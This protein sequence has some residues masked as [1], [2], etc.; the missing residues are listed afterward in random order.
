MKCPNCKNKIES[1]QKFCNYCGAPIPPKSQKK[2]NK[3]VILPVGVAC[4]CGA[5]VLSTILLTNPQ[6]TSAGK[7]EKKI[8]AGNRYLQQADYEKAEVAFNEALSID[9]K[10]SDAALG[11]AK[12]CNEKKNPEGAIK[13]LELATDNLEEMKPDQVDKKEEKDWE[14]KSEEYKQTFEDTNRLF[15]EKGNTKQAEYVQQRQQKAQQTFQVIQTVK[16]EE[17]S[18]APE[19]KGKT[20][21]DIGEMTIMT[22]PAEEK[23]SQNKK[24]KDTKAGG[25]SK[26]HG[27]S[28]SKEKSPTPTPTEES[29]ILDGGEG[30]GETEDLIDSDSPVSA[31][32]TPE[33]ENAGAVPGSKTDENTSDS[34]NGGDASGREITTDTSENA[35]GNGDTTPEQ[36][37]PQ[38]PEDLLNAYVQNEILG[39]APLLTSQTWTY[40]F[41]QSNIQG[42]SGN[43]AYHIADLDGDEEPE[44]LLVKTENG[45]MILDIYRAVDGNVVLSA[46]ATGNYNGFAGASLDRT[47]GMSQLC[48]LKDNGGT[49]SIGIVT[50]SFGNL[51]AEGNPSVYTGVELYNLN[52]DSLDRAAAVTLWDGIQVV[53]NFDLNT[54]S[55]EGK[56]AFLSYLNQ[57]G[58]DGSWIV[59]NADALTA[60]DFANNQTQDIAAIP[61]PLKEGLAAKESTVVTDLAYMNGLRVQ[62]STEMTVNILDHPAA[63]QFAQAYQQPPIQEPAADEIP[64]KMDAVELNGEEGAEVSA[65][66][67][68]SSEQ[69]EEQPENAEA[70]QSEENQTKEAG[71]EET[72]EEENPSE[73]GSG[74][75]AEQQMTDLGIPAATEDGTYTAEPQPE[76]SEGQEAPADNGANGEIVTPADE[77]PASEEPASENPAE[78]GSVEKEDPA[79]QAEEG[80]ETVP[81]GAEPEILSPDELLSAYA[82]QGILTACPQLASQSYAYDFGMGNVQGAD[83]VLGIHKT[84]LNGDGMPEL[85]VIRSQSGQMVWD[86]YQVTDNMVTL[87]SSTTPRCT[88][89]GNA[90]EEENYKMTQVCFLKDNGGSFSIGIASSYYGVN[91]GDG[92]PSVCTNLELYSWSGVNCDLVNAVT[93]LN[94][95]TVY[96]NNDKATAQEGG[97]DSFMAQLSTMGLN[98]GWI[99]ES[100]DPLLEMNLPENPEQDMSGVPDP[101]S[102]GLSSRESGVQDLAILEGNMSAGSGSMN[103]SVQNNTTY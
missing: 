20:I 90:M 79:Q 27:D 85:L 33:G 21:G 15:L 13:Y 39:A 70:V 38:P 91:E 49:Y 23:G 48:F 60:M 53:T 10:S 26:K 69:T 65:S 46:S 88:S 28:S 58:L 52:G 89:L 76:T 4:V 84:D 103:I 3:Q 14:K 37:L 22:D 101:L 7:L 99:A 74:D 94:G 62:G 98:G 73:T 102:T 82:E 9:E 68:E 16:T 12:V 2:V 47:S 67:N 80:T 25:S 78:T 63:E 93:I 17:Y 83:G 51:D 18:Q 8:E 55:A 42:F 81:E 86:I 30:S 75:Q 72:V 66:E 43:L 24:G 50:Y 31:S 29:K 100:A 57:F 44:L 92:N 61:D 95:S 36:S 41:E 56:T 35:G 40:D 64:D 54:L 5:V 96:T 71:T 34:E 1:G 59:E 97:K 87:A 32:V 11:L 19:Y 45:Q 6:E 77:N